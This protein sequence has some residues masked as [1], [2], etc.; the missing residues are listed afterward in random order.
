M[1]NDPS[2]NANLL[3]RTLRFWPVALT[4]LLV[5]VAI[6]SQ[7]GA[8]TEWME[9]RAASD[10]NLLECYIEREDKWY[11]YMLCNVAWELDLLDCD[12]DALEDL[13]FLDW[14]DKEK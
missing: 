7:E 6:H 2:R 4:L 11:G 3:R 10:D 8:G 13:C 5:P 9:C 14:C 1:T 12:F